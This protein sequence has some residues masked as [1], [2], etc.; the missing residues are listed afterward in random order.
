M[1]EII[2]DDLEMSKM[3]EIVSVLEWPVVPVETPSMRN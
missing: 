3:L 1:S 2:V